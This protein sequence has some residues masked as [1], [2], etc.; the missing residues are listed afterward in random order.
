IDT[1][2]L[3]SR[4]NAP[5]APPDA[6]DSA[7][8]TPATSSSIATTPSPLQSP[9]QATGAATARSAPATSSAAPATALL[10]HFTATPRT[11]IG[12]HRHDFQDSSLG[13]RVPTGGR[14]SVGAGAG[15]VGEMGSG[16]PALPCRF[17]PPPPLPAPTE[18]RPPDLG[19]AGTAAH[20][21]G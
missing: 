14:R 19:F 3:P 17:H 15:P 11:S 5:H 21:R 4:S 2:P 20:G 7:C 8:A 10:S 1:L 13:L 9:G 6:V 12:P 16:R 18:R